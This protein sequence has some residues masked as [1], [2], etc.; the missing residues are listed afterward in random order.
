MSHLA[1]SP[2]FS[3]AATTDACL[4][5]HRPPPL[6][7]QWMATFDFRLV[8]LLLAGVWGGGV[9]WRTRSGGQ[10]TAKCVC[11][12]MHIVLAWLWRVGRLETTL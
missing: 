10:Q 2:L 1:S 4:L 3:P 12:C 7:P 9:S 5:L 8:T 6:P 11:M